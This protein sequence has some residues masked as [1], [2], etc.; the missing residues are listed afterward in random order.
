MDFT[1]LIQEK[2]CLGV[3]DKLECWSKKY[4]FSKLCPEQNDILLDY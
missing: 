1:I 4:Y 3:A 2:A